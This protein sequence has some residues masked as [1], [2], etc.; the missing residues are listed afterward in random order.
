M[1]VREK[2]FVI[3]LSALSTLGSSLLLPG[4]VL[5][6]ETCNGFLSIAYPQFPTS[7]PCTSPDGLQCTQVG[8]GCSCCIR[9]DLEPTVVMRIVLGAGEIA[10]GNNLQVFNFLAELDCRRFLPLPNIDATCAPNPDGPR[11]TFTDTVTT[12]CPSTPSPL[13]TFPGR[14]RLS[15]ASPLN[16]CRSAI[17]SLPLHRLSP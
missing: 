7:P 3:A 11:V 14:L 4:S 2:L 8:Q 15:R 12:T 1:N 16:S 13:L 9:G 6:Q 10:G 5:G 17:P